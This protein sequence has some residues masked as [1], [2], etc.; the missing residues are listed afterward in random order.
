LKKEKYAGLTG[1]ILVHKVY[2]QKMKVIETGIM[3][4]PDNDDRYLVYC[5]LTGEL[6]HITETLDYVLANYSVRGD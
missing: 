1:M 6:G 5:R 4:T 2:K 3:E